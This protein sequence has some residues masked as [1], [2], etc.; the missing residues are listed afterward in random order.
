MNWLRFITAF[1]LASVVI[2]LILKLENIG[3]DLICG[4]IVLLGLWELAALKKQSLIMFFMSTVP[5][6]VLFLAGREY[7]VLLMILCML[8]SLIWIGIGIDIS[9][10]KLDSFHSALNS[11]IIGLLLMSGVWSALVLIHSWSN[12]APLFLISVLLMI[13]AADSFAYLI[14]KNFGHRKL[15]PELSPGKTIEG[16]LGGVFG[17]LVFALVTGFALL[18]LSGGQLL[19]WIGLGFFL[20]VVS[21]IGDLYESRLKRIAC[22][23]DSGRILP[24]H[25]GIL[26][27]ID[28]MLVTL[29]M[30]ATGWSLVR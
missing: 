9:V 26:D 11:Y 10:N 24:G 14:G 28:S 25:G 4:L 6:V 8:S 1:I 12:E 7:P 13:W 30:V 19:L 23:K 29:P 5:L 15:A 17:T 22:V 21:V 16:F 3:F 27:R 2:T 18:G 20:S